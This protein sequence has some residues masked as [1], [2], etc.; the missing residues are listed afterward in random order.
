MGVMHQHCRTGY[1]ARRASFCMAFIK[2]TVVFDLDFRPSHARLE[3]RVKEPSEERFP[4]P[5]SCI[6]G[7]LTGQLRPLLD[8]T[9]GDCL[10]CREGEHLESSAEAAAIS[11]KIAIP[12]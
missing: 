5:W 2:A 8:L 6:R 11:S 9:Q 12:E 10:R 1:F 7:G 4:R 3:Q